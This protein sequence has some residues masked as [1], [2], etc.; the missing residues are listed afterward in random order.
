MPR[1]LTNG[2]PLGDISMAVDNVLKEADKWWKDFIRNN[3]DL[4]LAAADVSSETW[5]LGLRWLL[6]EEYEKSKEQE[7]R[8]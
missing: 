7:P 4:A 6:G 1:H 3:Y 5:R 8:S 2:D